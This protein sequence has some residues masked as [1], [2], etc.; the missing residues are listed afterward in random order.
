ML[1]ECSNYE[2]Y[3]HDQEFSKLTT[4]TTSHSLNLQHIERCD[5][6]QDC[7]VQD[8]TYNSMDFIGLPLVSNNSEIEG[9]EG[10]LEKTT[11][12][13]VGVIDSYYQ[14]EICS[15][16]YDAFKRTPILQSVHDCDQET[17]LSGHGFL[18]ASILAGK[19][20]PAD[21]FGLCQEGTIRG[22]VPDAQ[23]HLYAVGCIECKRDEEML[24]RAVD[25]A[26]KDEV[27]VISMSQGLRGVSFKDFDAKWSFDDDILA[28][29][30]L[31]AFRNNILTCVPAGNDGPASESLLYGYPW[32][33]NVGACTT[34]KNLITKVTLGTQKPKENSLNMSRS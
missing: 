25:L 30:T 23:L 8:Q 26:I 28:Q 11:G 14:S 31:E 16:D 15:N 20:Q 24:A 3:E 12:V 13:K 21:F 19:P 9:L 22:V 18:C 7:I 17:K 33:V 10:V 2:D 32:C 29:R 4:A 6:E 1:K 5:D 34:G 27:R